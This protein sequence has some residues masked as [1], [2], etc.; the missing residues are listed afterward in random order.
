MKIHD[1][2]YFMGFI[3]RPI[4]NYLN[5]FLARARPDWKNRKIYLK[6]VS[7]TK[8]VSRRSRN[9]TFVP[10]GILNEIIKN[11]DWHEHYDP[12]ADMTVGEL[13]HVVGTTYYDMS[14]WVTDHLYLSYRTKR[15]TKVTCVDLTF[16]DDEDELIA[17]EI[18]L[19]NDTVRAITMDDLT[20]SVCMKKG[21]E[22]Q[23][24]CSCDSKFMLQVMGEIGEA[25][26]FVF[27]I[28]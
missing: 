3:A 10:D 28:K 5:L 26:R 24:D 8:K 19:A 12:N 9:Q 16:C 6:R 15:R 7:K 1:E 18:K 14:P 25:M 21:D 11:G 2:S 13:L 23:V 27:K 22:I 17:R 20:L 4:F